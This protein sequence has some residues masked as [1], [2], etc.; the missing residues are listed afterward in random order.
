SRRL[1]LTALYFAFTWKQWRRAAAMFRNER[2]RE[3]FLAVFGPLS[4]LGLAAVW[5][6]SL[7]LGFA[8]MQWSTGSSVSPATGRFID[9]LYLSGTT[10]FTL[11]LGDVRPVGHV[12]RLITVAEAGTGFA[13][14][15]IVIA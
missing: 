11:G 2:P 9:D 3:R 15:A 5:A 8:G 13:F 1:R 4:L 14:L 10:F 7:L 12:A 6:L